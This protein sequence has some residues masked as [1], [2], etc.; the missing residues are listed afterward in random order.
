MDLQVAPVDAVIVVD[1]HL[2]EL[3]VLV[4]ERLHDAVELLEHQIETSESIGFEL[5]QLLL[6]GRPAVRAATR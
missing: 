4:C 6:K 3:H 2:R 5:L 1:H